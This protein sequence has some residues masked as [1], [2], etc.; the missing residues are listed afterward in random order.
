MNKKRKDWEDYE[1]SEDSEDYEDSEDSEDS[2]SKTK[3]S[4]TVLEE[5]SKTLI[6][7][8]NNLSMADAKP[9]IFYDAIPQTGFPPSLTHLYFGDSFNERIKKNVLPPSLT[10]LYFGKSFNRKFNCV[11]L[12]NLTHL[13]FGKFFNKKLQLSSSITNLTLGYVSTNIKFEYLH[14]LQSLTS[15]R[16]AY[17][18]SEI[19]PQFLQ[20]MLGKGWNIVG[21]ESDNNILYGKF[22]KIITENSLQTSRKR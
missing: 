8:F 19:K 1:D 12:P 3:K 22:V 18:G 2:T 6:V 14:Q 11:Y 10:H 5:D 15:V 20:F 17:E 13:Y 21:Y 7:D 16:I 4:K 9:V